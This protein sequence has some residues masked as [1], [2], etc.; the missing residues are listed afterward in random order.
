MIAALGHAFVD[1]QS[2]LFFKFA[3]YTI[4]HFVIAIGGDDLECSRMDLVKCDV[5]MKIVGIDMRSCHILV[6]SIS[7][8]FGICRSNFLEILFR[9]LVFFPGTERNYHVV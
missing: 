8:P 4:K 6:F 5:H 2:V 1:K 3:R 9:Q 7:K